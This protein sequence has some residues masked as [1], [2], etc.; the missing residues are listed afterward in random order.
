MKYKI[1]QYSSDTRL[2]PNDVLIKTFKY[3]IAAYLYKTF[4]YD[5]WEAGPKFFVTWKILRIGKY[6][7]KELSR[8]EIKDI[9]G[10]II[11]KYQT[12]SESF[13]HPDINVNIYYSD[14]FFNEDENKN[15]ILENQF[16]YSQ[17]K[18]SLSR[19]GFLIEYQEYID[20]WLV[21]PKLN[22]RYDWQKIGF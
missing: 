9:T 13:Y 1:V 20:Q 18:K 7:K 22:I 5:S 3:W 19:Q 2:Y 14:I 8:K 21:K 11:Y 17:I 6:P 4:K 15:N 16:I 12:Y 10:Q